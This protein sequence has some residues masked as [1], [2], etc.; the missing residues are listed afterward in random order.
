MEAINPCV[1]T[2]IA[3]I[4]AGI[5]MAIYGLEM[6]DIQMRFYGR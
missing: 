4:I 3:S 5:S 1:E 6:R 2:Q